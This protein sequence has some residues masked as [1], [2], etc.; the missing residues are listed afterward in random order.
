VDVLGGG[1]RFEEGGSGRKLLRIQ[2]TAEVDGVRRD[3][4]I[5]FGRYGKATRPRAAPT[6]ERRQMPRS[7][8]LS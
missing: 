5:T 6:S 7:S 8:P 1:A 4:T 3:Y 2:I